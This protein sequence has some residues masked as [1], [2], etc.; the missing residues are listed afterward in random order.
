MENKKNNISI[1]AVLLIIAIIVIIV[2]GCVVY[3][4][5]NSKEEPPNIITNEINNM[6]E[7][8]QAQETAKSFA[9]AVNQ[10]DWE[11]AE[12]Y[13]NSNVVN[14]LKKYKVSN[15]SLKL[16]TLEENPNNPN[17]Y[18]LFD[19]YDIDY[20]GLT[21]KDIGLGRIFCIEKINGEYV[22]TSFNA[23]GY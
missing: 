14:D 12:K 21:I 2:I 18:Y 15:M 20:N 3:T 9:N 1:F 8:E 4:L 10:K 5:L 11:L 16:D 7:K 19:L 17:G 23:T 6:T 13:S 22:V